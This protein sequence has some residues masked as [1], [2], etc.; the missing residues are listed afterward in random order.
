MAQYQAT[1][2]PLNLTV[3]ENIYVV[4]VFE[5]LPQITPTPSLTPGVSV[6]PRVSVTP[7]PTS[8]PAASPTSLITVRIAA[9]VSGEPA[10]VVGGRVEF[11]SPSINSTEIRVNSPATII[12]KATPAAGFRFIHWES[13]SP[14]LDTIFVESQN[15]ETNLSVD[16]DTT[17]YAVFERITVTPTP[18][19]SITQTPRVTPGISPTPTP[20]SVS[21][22]S[23][24]D[25]RINPGS[26][27]VGYVQGIYLG[28]SGGICWEPGTQIG[29]TPSLNNIEFTYQRGT[30]SFPQ[31]IS[32]V[33]QNPSYSK[34][35]RV[36]FSTNNTF[37]VVNP[38]VLNLPPR[39]QQRFTVSVK[40]DTINQIDDGKTGFGLQV[41]IIPV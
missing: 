21:W 30:A 5:P 15:V 22:K 39:G 25:G 2:N 20:S 38:S 11:R 32:F 13:Y 40:N 12:V 26:P 6:T 29:F 9:V 37:F 16:K 24:I 18:T 8:T 19:P 7:V 14:M 27:P 36:N 33:A 23:C 41:E 10:S 35:Y 4:P 1:N 3:N 17:Y 28:E 31:P 34:S